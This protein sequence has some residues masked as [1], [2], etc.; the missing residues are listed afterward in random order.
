MT[1]AG[2]KRGGYTIHY[3][4]DAN[5]DLDY[6]GRRVKSVVRAAVRGFLEDQPLRNEGQRKRLDPNPLDAGWRLQIGD[7]RAYYNVSEATGVVTILRV[8]HKPRETL[9]LRGQPVQ[10]R[11]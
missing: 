2:R 7:Y 4:Y 1:V 8:G 5:D 9:Y 3:T 10:M 6:L 11:D